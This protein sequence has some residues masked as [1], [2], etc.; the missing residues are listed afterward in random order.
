VNH[1]IFLTL[2][3]VP[4]YSHHKLRKLVLFRRIS[5][6]T[7]VVTKSFI[8][9]DITPRS[10]LKINRHF[11]GTYFCALWALC[12]PRAL[13]LVSCT[14]YSSTLTMEATCSSETSVVFKPTTRRYI[15]EDRALCSVSF[16][17]WQNQVRNSRP[18]WPL[19]ELVSN[20]GGPWVYMHPNLFQNINTRNRKTIV[21][22][23][24]I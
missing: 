18:L 21:L 24:Y 16:F 12:L 5:G 7:T 13:T 6:F 19:A 1:H 23:S 10:P 15:P 17:G 20:H 2:S 4:V 3:I 14:A 8:F 11:G 9:W 22:S